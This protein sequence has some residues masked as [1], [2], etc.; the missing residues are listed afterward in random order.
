MKERWPRSFIRACGG[1][2]TTRGV[3]RYSGGGPAAARRKRRS[4][5]LCLYHPQSVRKGRY[6]R[7]VS[8]ISCAPRG[9]LKSRLF[10]FRLLTF[11]GFLLFRGFARGLL[12]GHFAHC[13]SLLP[14]LCSH[15]HETTPSRVSGGT[16]R[17]TRKTARV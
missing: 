17:T 7:G 16:R 1:G 14:S 2:Q 15:R 9:W 5:G 13:C 6:G 3:G 10:P 11:A 12:R 4:R 8:S